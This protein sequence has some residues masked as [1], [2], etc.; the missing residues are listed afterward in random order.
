MKISDL[1]IIKGKSKKRKYYSRGEVFELNNKKFVCVKMRNGCEFC[2][3]NDHKN[4][5]YKFCNLVLCSKYERSDNTD[6]IFIEV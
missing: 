2:A 3:F 4:N 5:Y 1:N 6:V